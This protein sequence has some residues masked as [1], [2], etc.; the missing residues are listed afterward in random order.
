V[1]QGA[2]RVSSQW[3]RNP[4]VLPQAIFFLQTRA[5]ILLSM[6]CYAML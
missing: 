2:P 4:S 3:A 6:L 5:G 1:A